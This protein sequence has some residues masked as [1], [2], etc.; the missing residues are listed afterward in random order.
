MKRLF[1]ILLITA[2]LCLSLVAVAQAAPAP[3]QPVTATY[4][5]TTTCGCQQQIVTDWY[6]VTWYGAYTRVAPSWSLQGVLR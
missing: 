3:W 1:T 2:I 4:L 5:Y 6:R